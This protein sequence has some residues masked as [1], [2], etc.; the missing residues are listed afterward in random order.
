MTK[1][2]FKKF[3]K[4]N[5]SLIKKVTN[6]DTS[7]QKLYEIYELYGE[8][9]KA[10]S[11]YLEKTTSAET[12]IKELISII[13]GLDMEKVRHGIEG[14]QKTI[15]LIQDLGFGKTTTDSSYQARPVYKHFE[16]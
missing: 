10:W 1:E 3:V 15:S 14:V 9:D 11:N 7:W 6:G 13:K 8:D 5:P 16:D 2:N 4:N 12:S